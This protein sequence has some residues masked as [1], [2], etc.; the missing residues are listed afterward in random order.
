MFGVVEMEEALTCLMKDRMEL[1]VV[2][3]FLEDFEM[4]EIASWEELSA[5]NIRHTI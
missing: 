2:F 1:S 3:E 4:L 5:I